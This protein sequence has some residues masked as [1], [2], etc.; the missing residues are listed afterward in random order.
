MPD[1]CAAD[2]ELVGTARR[3][4]RVAFGELY[5]RYARMVHGLLLARVRL[6]RARLTDHR[7][8]LE[9]GRIHARIWA[10]PRLFF[11]ETPS[12]VAVDL[13]CVY[14][15]EVDHA[16]ASLIKVEAGWVAW[17]LNGRESFVPAGAQ[18]ATRPGVG[19]GT[20]YFDDVTPPFREALAHVDFGP[21]GADARTSALDVVLTEARRRD[22]F[23]L[24]HLLARVDAS[25]RAKVYDTLAALVPP[26]AGVARDRVLA[27]DRDMLD[28]WWDALGLDSA[29]WWRTWKGKVAR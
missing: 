9:R 13:G 19:P 25:S 1:D 3:G 12:A 28:R 26:P 7:L 23:T 11:V 16:G 4:N 24:W 10:P 8:A 21:G 6:V 17:E 22:A 5:R 27:G 2:A 15:L 18:C 20:P 29:A 14:T